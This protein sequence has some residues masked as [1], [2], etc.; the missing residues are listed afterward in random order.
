[1]ALCKDEHEMFKCGVQIPILRIPIY[2]AVG[3][4]VGW[5]QQSSCILDYVA[6]HT[7]IF[8]ENMANR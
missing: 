4:I 8:G 5:P 3:N 6:P 7:L 2:S 1:M